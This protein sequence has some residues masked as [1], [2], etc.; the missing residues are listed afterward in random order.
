VGGGCIQALG[1]ESTGGWLHAGDVVELEIERVG[2]PL[3][4]I[5][6]RPADRLSD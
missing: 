1:P 5:G 4:R 2:V 6:L 3:H